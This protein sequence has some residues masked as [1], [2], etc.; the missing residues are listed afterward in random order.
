[1]F[2]P[3]RDQARTFLIDAWRKRCES[4]PATPLETMAA[5]IA[6]EHPEYHALL[7]GREDALAKNWTPDSGETNPFLH[8]SLHLAIAEQLQIDQPPGIRAGFEQLCQRLGDRHE[9]LHNILDCLGETIWQSQRNN[10]P[11]DGAAYLE[12]IQ[13]KAGQ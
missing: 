8:L 3:T 5:D 13:R 10:A 7:A 6:A 4:L 2:S 11:P 9:A 1:M 12:C